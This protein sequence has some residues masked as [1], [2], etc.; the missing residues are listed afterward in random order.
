MPLLLDSLNEMG[1]DI[2]FIDQK[3]PRDYIQNAGLTVVK[4]IQW[5]NSELE[6]EGSYNKPIVLGASMGGLIVRYA[7]RMMELQGCCHN[8][9]IYATFDSPHNGANISISSQYFVKDLRDFSETLIPKRKW[10]GLKDKIKKQI[11]PIISS[12]DLVLNSP[13]ARQMLIYHREPNADS[14]FSSFY[15]FLDS[16]GQPQNCRR[17]SIVNGSEKAVPNT[18]SSADKMLLSMNKYSLAPETYSPNPGPWYNWLVIPLPKKLIDFKAYSE[19]KPIIYEYNDAVL[20]SHTH[21]IAWKQ[22]YL[23]S[24][25]GMTVTDLI[26]SLYPPLYLPMQNVKV[27]I[28]SGAGI[29]FT[30]LNAEGTTIYNVSNASYP[31]SYT[32]V[33]GSR[34]ETFKEIADAAKT[35]VLWDSLALIEAGTPSHTFMPTATTLDMHESNL[36]LNIKNAYL[37]DPSITPFDSYWAPKRIEG[38]DEDEN[39]LHVEVREQN[40]AWIIEQIRN[41]WELRNYKG[42]YKGK[43]S[44][45]YNYGHPRPGI[46]GDDIVMIN[47]PHQT[48][49]YSLDIENNGQLFVNKQDKIGLKTGTLYPRP[50]STFELRTNSE[51]CDSTIV[52]IKDGGKFIIGEEHNGILNKGEVHFC[53]NSTLEIFGNGSLIVSDSSQLIIEDGAN[54]IIHPG[55]VVLLEGS[56]SILELKGKVTIAD[57]AALAPQGNGY[58]RFAARMNA[59]NI[60]DYWQAGNESSLVLA[61]N[62][63]SQSKKAEVIETTYL[64]DDL[65]QFYTNTTIE[66]DSMVTLHSY[67]SIQAQNA[68]FTAMDSTK[69]YNAVKIY[70]QSNTRFGS[71]VFKNGHY[72]LSAQM[73]YGNN[74]FTLDTCTFTKN[75]IGLYTSDQYIFINK[76]DFTDNLDYGWKAENMQSNCD[77]AE[78]IFDNNGYAGA[79]FNGQGN[80]TLNVEWSKF[81]NNYQ[82]GMEISEAALNS[83]CSRYQSNGQS[84][85]FA[86]E[87]AEIDISGDKMNQITNN[88]TGILLDKALLINIENGFNN[89]NGNK[90]FIVGEVKP[91]NYYQGLNSATPICLSYNLLPAPSAMQMPI[92]I[93]LTEPQNGNQITVPLIDW[94]QNLAS[95]ETYCPISVEP[96]NFNNYQMFIGKISTSVISTSYFQNTYLI[97]AFKIAAMQMSYGDEY[98]GNDT[99]AISLF[100]EIFDNIPAS[101]NEDEQDAIYDALDQMI[102]ALTYAIEHELID[103]NRAL[104]GM[105]VDEYVGMIEEEIQNRLDDVDYANMYAEEQEAYYQLLLAQMYRAAEHYD[106]ALAILQNDNYFFNTTLKNQAD[107]WNCVCIAENL[108]LKD[109]IERSEYVSRIDSCHDISAAKTGGFYPIFGINTVN[110]DESENKLV[111]IYPNPAQQLIAVEFSKRIKEATIELSDITGKLIWSTYQKV[112]GKQIRLKLPELNSSTYML[113]ITTKNGVYNNKVIIR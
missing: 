8:T 33:P 82:H 109:S 54:L 83:S 63:G 75:Y 10:F 108:L 89:F 67:G 16:I 80:V 3:D 111:A 18:I 53:K 112:K 70:G 6:K 101:V 5:V 57:K 64:P 78:S 15:S 95:Y 4:V 103:P 47:K 28:K 76:C 99:L 7:L 59:S 21:G 72:G 43:L 12:Y 2:I 106:Y 77:V 69:F 46:S 73:S 19:S 48:I 1:Y 26:G 102:S 100:K 40:R 24:S 32:E 25:L 65:N 110:L 79:Y 42:E 41:D 17:L 68:L 94:T 96:A 81:R 9:R 39:M 45:Y 86:K 93:Y 34:S 27:G 107:Y 29:G 84:G 66:L 74:A 97:D 90:Y 30:Y 14:D 92:N 58:I 55:A 35:K 20:A 85:I 104:D 60:N 22:L 98:I 37:A 44:A 50:G 23:Y 11:A 49:L 71:C 88:Y 113:K 31:V 36:Y 52:R 105:P 87:N 62:S 61:N 13:A 91:D 56:A 38:S 51:P